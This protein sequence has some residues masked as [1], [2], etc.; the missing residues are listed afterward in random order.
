MSFENEGIQF[1]EHPC[2]PNEEIIYD[3]TL[4]DNEEA[5]VIVSM[6]YFAPPET[7]GL[8]KIIPH[9]YHDF[10]HL[11]GEKL[12]AKLPDHRKFDH[13]IEILP[14]KEVPFGPIDSLSEPQKEVLRKYLD[15]MIGQGKSPPRNP[16]PEHQSCSYPRK[17][18]NYGSVSIIEDWTT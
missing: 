5:L 18:E 3:E 10:L 17:S 14:G 13:A 4:L 9:E 8:K 11:F 12:A 7:E 16:R 1:H 2:Q 15:R 6:T